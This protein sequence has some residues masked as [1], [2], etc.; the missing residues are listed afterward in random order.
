MHKPVRGH[1]HWLLPLI[2]SAVIVSS[3]GVYAIYNSLVNP[4]PFSITLTGVVSLR[5]GENASKITFK[6]QTS[7]N[8]FVSNVSVGNPQ[9]YAVTLPNNNL[10][11]VA[12]T[13]ASKGNSV[14][15]GTLDL[16]SNEKS[17]E[18]NWFG[19]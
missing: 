19:K 6:C 5:T 18:H 14:D 4:M 11:R 3:V 1:P 9:T 10:Y 2:L 17:L 12:I 16:N 8:D 13:V 15:V 7:G